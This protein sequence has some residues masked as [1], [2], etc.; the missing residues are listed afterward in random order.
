[1]HR[2]DGRHLA[3]LI[4]EQIRTGRFDALMAH[5]ALVSD[6]LVDAVTAAGGEVYAWTVDDPGLLERLVAAGVAGVTTNDP[7][8]FF[9][10]RQ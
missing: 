8:V 3:R 6:T 9:Q 10:S 4:A 5:H 7:G 1:L 2:G